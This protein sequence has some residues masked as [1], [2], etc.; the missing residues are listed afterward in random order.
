[1]KPSEIPPVGSKVVLT[2]KPYEVKGTVVHAGN[3]SVTI[4]IYGVLRD[5]SYFLADIVS[6]KEGW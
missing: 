5:R 1:M 2:I 6:C 3:M 4:K